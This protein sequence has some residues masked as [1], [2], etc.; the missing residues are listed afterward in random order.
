MNVALL[1]SRPVP[2]AYGGMDRLLDGL[3][4]ALAERHPTDLI[5][6]DVDE[7]DENGVLRGYYDF[8]NLDLHDFDLVFTTKAPSFM[9]RHPA[10]VPYVPHRIRVFYDRY[11]PRGPE[12][13]RLRRLIHWMDA[14]ALSPER[15]PEIFAISQTVCDRL[16]RWGGRKATP[17]HTPTTFRPD[18]P[19]PGEHFLS[20]GRLHPW[21]RVDLLIRAVLASRADAP[22]VIVGAGPQEPE[23]RAVAGGDPRIRFAGPVDEAQLRDLYARSLA[24]LFPPLNEDLGL[25]AWEAFLSGKPVVT[26]LDAGEP[27][28]IVEDAKTGWICEPTPQ[29]IAGRLE[30]IVAGR[31]RLDAMI[32]ACRA[33][34]APVTWDRVADTLLA[35]GRRRLDQTTR[36]SAIPVTNA[37]KSTTPT[38]IASDADRIRLLVTDNQIVDPPVGGGRIRIWELYRHLPD[39]FV[40]TY[41]GTHDHPGPL[42]RDQWLARNFR[43][44]IM[45]LTVLH[46]K[47]HEIWRRLTAGDATV[48]VTIPLLLGRCSPRYMRLIRE[49]A[50]CADLLIAAHPWMTPFLPRIDG[51]P[52]VYDSQN[53]EAAV[54]ASLLGRTLAG[55]WLARR[56]A[57]VERA[58]VERAALTLACSNADAEQFVAR[59]G[60]SPH[61]IVPVPNGV[62]CERIR[63]G[64]PDDRAALR[65]RFSLPDDPIAIFVG[66]DYPPNEETL[67]FLA[68]HVAPALPAIAFAVIGGVG[69]GWRARRLPDPPAN[70]RLI[71]AVDDDG[72]LAF[73]RGADLAV[74]PMRLGSGTNIKMLDYLAAGLPIVAT[75]EGARGIDGRP[76][77][78]WIQA[79]RD[80]FAAA[81]GELAACD[82]IRRKLAAH[83]R[84][85]AESRYDW[86]VI[87]A[88]CAEA[89]RPLARH[90]QSGRD[91]G[92]AA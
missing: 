71:G 53:C 79:G 92:R 55:R 91:G 75:A 59:Y 90:R 49:H 81:L 40:T 18:P 73:Y 84:R 46:F 65:R 3:H 9:I 19:R 48:D 15:A 2:L 33:A 6:L 87:A 85:L 43:E 39:D 80:G 78:H 68:D 32:E 22:L 30:A 27:A 12:F 72:L 38:H 57:A 20:V 58:A 45:P 88:A 64:T 25:I 50:E 44:I 51:L 56:V 67:R 61:R 63:P 28:L 17:L 7:R 47:M 11:E 1:S 52:L 66:S 8:Y 41:V 54:K 76:D 82:E 23:L 69:D 13:A 83:C 31:D 60:A 10:H 86:R 29:A 24:V 74:N 4:K 14:W 21:K 89:L 35:A 36:R 37:A 34:V 77:E 26:T 5:Q 62:D 42:A 70:V 16:M